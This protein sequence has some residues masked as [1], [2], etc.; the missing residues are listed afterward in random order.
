MDH[1]TMRPTV[2]A[3]TPGRT[4]KRTVSGYTAPA[5]QPPSSGAPLQMKGLKTGR[6]PLRIWVPAST[7]RGKFWVKSSPGRVGCPANAGM[8]KIAVGRRTSRMIGQR[9]SERAESEA[10]LGKDLGILMSDHSAFAVV[11]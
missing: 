5:F 8:A 6:C 7:R 4:A 11:P 10:V 9:G 2:H 1:V 3:P